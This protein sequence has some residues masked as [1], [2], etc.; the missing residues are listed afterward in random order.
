MLFSGTLHL[1]DIAQRL[2]WLDGKPFSLHDYPMYEAVYNGRYRDTLLMCGRQ[3]AKSTSLANFII[4]ESIALP[5][6]REYYVSPTKEQTLIFS[7]TRV[8]KTLAYSP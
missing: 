4:T 1:A 2:L 5:F 7:N 6:F 8:G 3:V